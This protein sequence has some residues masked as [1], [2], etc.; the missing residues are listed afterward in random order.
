M[1]V[2]GKILV[3]LNL[4]FSLV[5]G[6]FAVMDYTARTHWVDG[7]NTLKS[8]YEVL[9]AVS[10]TYKTEADKLAKEK[11]DLYEKL[12]KSGVK[13]L[14]P[15]N[16]EEGLRAAE[17]AIALINDQAKADRRVA[18]GRSPTARKREAGRQAPGR[19]ATARWSWR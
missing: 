13:V 3:F 7:Y 5:V 2:V 11:E 19:Q 17:H 16:K 18:D 10:T 6:A 12:N 9:Q 8:R 4:V 15:A 1:T 14:D